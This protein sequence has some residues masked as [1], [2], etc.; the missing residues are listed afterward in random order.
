[1]RIFQMIQCLLCLCPKTSENERLC[2]NEEIPE[3]DMKIEGMKNGQLWQRAK[4]KNH[5][6]WKRL[7]ALL[8]RVFFSVFLVGEIVL[9]GIF[10]R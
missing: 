10:V 4:G 6:D 9:A 2:D 7:A 5:E 3:T 1:M 8:D